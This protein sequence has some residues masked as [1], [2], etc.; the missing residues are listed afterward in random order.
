M[1]QSMYSDTNTRIKLNDYERSSFFESN[2]WVRQG[3]ALSPLLFNLFIADLHKFL[4]IDC[5]SP[6]LDKTSIDCLMYADN[7]LLMSETETGLQRILDRFGEYCD[8]WGM[9]VNTDKT[10][11]M[12]FSGNGHRCKT[13]TVNNF[14]SLFNCTPVGRASD[15]MMAPT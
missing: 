5:Q 1:M 12:K 3:D 7:L 2:T 13:V 6:E 11:I 14:A 15:S 4:Q 10:K 9:E 8:K